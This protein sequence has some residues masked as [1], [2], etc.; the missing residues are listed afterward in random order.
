VNKR[1]RGPD[2]LNKRDR[3][4]LREQKREDQVL[5]IIKRGHVTRTQEKGPRCGNK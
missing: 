1:E 4:R 3:A 5:G 2:C